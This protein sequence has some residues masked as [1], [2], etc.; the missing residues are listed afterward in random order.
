M[1]TTP[2]TPPELPAGPG[3]PGEAVPQEAPA[4]E[5]Q[6]EEVPKVSPVLPL[7]VASSLFMEGLDTSI[8][9]TALP[10]MAESFNVTA[11]QMT[12][13]ITAYLL[14]LAVFIPVSGWIAD[15]FG[16]RKV[17]CTAIAAFTLGSI[18][19][20][21]ANSIDMLIA[22]RLI[23]GFGGAMMTPV[24]RLILARS[25]PKDQLMRAMTFYM[26]PANLGPTVGPILGGAI[27]ATFGWQWN[28]FINVPFGVLGIAL[29]LRYIPNA[30]LPTTSRFDWWGY[31]ILA[32]GL[33]AAQLAL[34]NLTQPQI[35][36]TTQTLLMAAAA[37]LLGGYAL[38]AARTE[39]PVLDFRLFRQRVFGISIGFGNLL[40][41]ATFPVSFLVALLLQ[42]GFGLGPFET[43]VLFAF[44]TIGAV[45]MRANITNLARLFGLRRLLVTCSLITSAVTAGFVFFT[46]ETPHWFIAVYLFGFGVLRNAQ[47]QSVY[48]LSYAEISTEDMSKSTTITA[49]MQRGAQSMGVGLAASL[50]A[51]FSG[52]AGPMGPEPFRPVF[53]ALAAI[54]A[55]TAFGFARLKPE[56]GWEVSGYRPK[57]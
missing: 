37:C 10:R 38:Y 20:G 21:L 36:G 46:P 48:A 1:A 7:I 35:N 39:N 15:R 41:L 55:I 14:A 27:T 17:Y 22:G 45:T 40:R 24:G 57:N 2:Q 34:E 19:S 51:V 30:A 29:A 54:T 56:D 25:F 23:Q 6:S 4:A 12:S 5:G 16:A 13:A 26:L 8:V 33:A 47:H 44:F 11:P 9:N 32:A 53:L 52:A 31:L 28:F 50:L 3:T 43:G 42:V 18:M 49:L